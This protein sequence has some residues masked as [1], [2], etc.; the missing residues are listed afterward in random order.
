MKY[1]FIVN[2]RAGAENGTAKLNAAIEALPEKDDCEVYVT[3]APGDATVFVGKW[4][5]A[6]PGDDVRFIACGGDGTTNEVFSGAAGRENVSVT[7]Y[8]CGSGNDFVKVFGGA[9]K[10]LR[11]PALIA[12]KDRPLDL[13]KVGDRWANNVVNFGFDTTVAITINKE[14]EK[15]GH[16]NKS[17]YTKGV[18]KALLTSMN[19]SFT[20][21]ADGETLNPSGKAL[22]CTVANGQYVGGSFKCAPRAK[23][24]DGLI[25]VCL[26]RPISRL[27]FVKILTP[28]TNG[29]HLDREDMRDVVVYR[30]AKKVEVEAPEGFAYS[31]D[32]EIVYESRFTVE[33]VP[34]AV[35]FA[36]PD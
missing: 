8:P 33:I 4:C 7:C 5:D 28:Y 20:V 27:R 9:E 29:E 19:N 22:L 31:L 30:Q 1:V 23:T 14:R 3:K 34:G 2:P 10:F 6:H 24:D 21:K 16:G 36:V 13:L 26:I 18:V 32:G 12:A 35:R 15:T 11:V 17:A 25:E